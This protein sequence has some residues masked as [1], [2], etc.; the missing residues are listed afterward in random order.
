MS[1]HDPRVTLEQMRAHAR[2]ALAI[3]QGALLWQLGA[4]LY[5]DSV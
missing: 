5:A 1:Q 3:L 2:E 4:I